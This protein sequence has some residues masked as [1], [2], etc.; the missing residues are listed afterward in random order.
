MLERRNSI[1]AQLRRRVIAVASITILSLLGMIV[2]NLADT[3]A[4]VETELNI[5]AN[6]AALEFER[7]L[8]S[9]EN[10]LRA[11][12]EAIPYS[13]DRDTLFLKMLNRQATIFET[14][15]VDFDGDIL[16]QRRRL[17]GT[18]TM[19]LSQQPWL[20]V[21]RAGNIYIGPVSSEEFGV[22]FSTMAVPVPDATGTI[23]GALL[24]RVDLTALWSIVVGQKV[25]ESGYIYLADEDG[26]LLAYRELRLLGQ[27]STVQSLTGLTP[28][29]IT[30]G[31]TAVHDGVGGELVMSGGAALGFVPW[32]V[33]AEQ[34]HLEALRPFIVIAI[35][36]LALL[37]L[38]AIVLFSSW[39]FSRRRII[40]PMAVLQE[41]VDQLS[42]GNLNYEIEI[43]HQDELGALASTFNTMASQLQELIGSLEQRVADRTRA[44]ETSAEVSR[45]LSTILDQDHLVREVVEQLRSAFGYY[46]AHIYIYDEDGQFLV[47]AGG[48][49]NA[50]KTMLARG[51]KLAKGQGLVGRC[52]IS[53]QVVLIPDVALAE[54]W[55]PNPLL[56]ETRSELAVPIAVG[57]EVL[58]V[59]DVQHN[60]TGGLQQQ[61][62]D[63]VQAVANQVA[64]ALQNARAYRE[65]QR[66]AEREALVTTIGQRIQTATSVEDV[67]K[68]AVSELSRSLG[69]ARSKV[70]LRS[71]ALQDET[72]R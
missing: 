1:T 29:Q 20:E 44:L 5:S 7:F 43:Q 35:W 37:V 55:L 26:Q 52:A 9:V 60:I 54:G 47:M 21:V 2:L 57:Q 63:L 61:D 39:R 45:R 53:N 16:A 19:D 31:E 8:T 11:T 18:T 24:A 34:P 50:G 28:R 4:D 46:H 67:L 27:G 25:G 36:L 70:E 41:G 56:P 14:V 32:F 38:G 3:F 10:D 69:A 68:V 33:I 40:A 6:Q 66:R 23:S 51:H 59:L 65:T 58:G 17:G 72:Y 30:D 15:L 71:S 48:T 62:A 13:V 42:A 64:V 12:G 22:P 49:G